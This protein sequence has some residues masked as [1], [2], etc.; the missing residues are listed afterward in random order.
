VL[1]ENVFRRAAIAVAISASLLIPSGAA[2]AQSDEV[3]AAARALA[4]QGAEALKANKYAEALDLVKRAEALLH[5]PT[6]LLLIGR[7]Q[8]GLGRLVRAQETYLKLIREDL[9]PTAPAAFKNAQAAGKEDL[10]AI[11]P[12]IA[13]LRIVLDGVGKRKVTVKMDDQIVPPALVGVHRPVDPGK[14]EIG[15]FPVGGGPVKGSVELKEG[16]KKDIRLV[17]PEGPPPS[18]VPLNPADNPDVA[19]TPAVVTKDQAES[20][21]MTP[22]RGAGI[23][24]GAAGVVGVVVGA[25]FMAKGGSTQSSA[26]AAAQKYGC[27][28]GGLDCAKPATQAQRDAMN[29]IDQLD[30]DAAKQKTIGVIGLA[31][32][33]AA[34][35]GGV[36]LF[37]LGKPKHGSANKAGVEPWFGGTSFGL[38]GA[39]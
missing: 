35:A 22:L 29:D 33:G 6:H 15:V 27:T 13:S 32:G 14:H 18:G 1:S 30:K 24:V 20:K 16:E 36:T 4:T 2:H 26:D 25:V 39:F 34:L 9:A 17:V 21:F 11:E 3:K 31:A 19:K 37:L 8:V 23:G 7:A 10:A 28:N 12:K 38:R 5:A